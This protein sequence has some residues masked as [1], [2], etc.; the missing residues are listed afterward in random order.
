M[1]N[2]YQRH[3]THCDNTRDGCGDE[4]R[5][6]DI[7]ELLQNNLRASE[8]RSSWQ[9]CIE[10]RQDTGAYPEQIDLQCL[11]KSVEMIAMRTNVSKTNRELSSTESLP[12]PTH[13]VESEERFATNRL[14]LI[15]WLSV[16]H[17]SLICQ[18]AYLVI[19]GIQERVFHHN[20]TPLSLIH[21]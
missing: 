5:N 13:L 16:C 15:D 8:P 9:W 17:D 7:V 3:H 10:R 14:S 6:S 12:E 2:E 21:I 20:D 4:L 1:W 19:D 11:A 18:D